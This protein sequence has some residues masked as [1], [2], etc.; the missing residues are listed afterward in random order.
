MCELFEWRSANGRLKEMSCRVAM[1][2]M[3]RDGLIDLPAP[4][5]ARPRSYQVVATSA[6]DPQPEWGGTVNDLGQLKVVPVAR[7]APLRLWNEVVARHHYLGYKMLPGAQLRYFIRDGE[8]LLGAMG[9]GA[10]AWKVAPRD[11][12]IGWSSEERQQ[13]LH[14]IVGQSR[15]L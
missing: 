2:K 14:L 15:F 8:R 10:S 4:R 9:F 12:F 3:H 6:G 5:W 1:L 13:G 7:G 11:T